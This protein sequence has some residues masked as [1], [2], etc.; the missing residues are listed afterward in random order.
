MLIVSDLSQ[1][2]LTQRFDSFIMDNPSL[3]QHFTAEILAH[4][5][6]IHKICRVY[7]KDADDRNDLYQEIVLNAWQSFPR[8]EGRSKFST[9]L[10]RVAINTALYQTRKDKFFGK[11]SDL[12]SA[13]NQPEE[14]SNEDDLR[15]L[16]QAIDQLDPVDKSIVLLYLDELPYKEI[17][18]ITGLTETNVGVKLNRIKLKMK[19]LLSAYG[20]R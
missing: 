19:N 17:S 6:I 7:R 11:L 13:E 1:S 4:R 2:S 14:L 9:W 10:Y 15:L 20:A 3:V 5:G 18:E 12:D 16:Y 8:F